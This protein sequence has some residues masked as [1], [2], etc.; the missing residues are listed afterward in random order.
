MAEPRPAAPS[1]RFDFR[2]GIS[3]RGGVERTCAAIENGR[4]RF[5]H[6][7]LDDLSITAVAGC[8]L[9]PM[10]A[11]FLDLCAAIYIADRLSPRQPEGDVRDPFNRWHRPMHLIVPVR[12][13]DWWSQ[14]AIVA[15]LQELLGFLTDDRWSFEFVARTHLLRPSESQTSLFRPPSGGITVALHSGGLDSLLGLVALAKRTSVS[16]IV[17]VTVATGNSWVR[18]VADSVTKELRRAHSSASP[19]YLPVR[20]RIGIHTNGR[21]RNDREPSQR[22]RAMLFLVTG[23]VTALTAGSNRLS[24]CENGVGAISLPMSADHWGAHATKAMH[25]KT[26]TLMSKLA[27]I[28]FDEAMFIDNIGGLSTK[29]ELL[30]LLEDC[31]LTAAQ[32]TASCDQATYLRRGEACGRC[33][34]CL[35]RRVALTTGLLDQVIDGRAMKYQTDWFDRE[36]SWTRANS[37]HLMAMRHQVELLRNAIGDGKDFA[38]LDAAFPDLFEVT[39]LAP[40]LGLSVDD[41]KHRL[42]QLYVSHIREFD[43]FIARIDRQGW[44]RRATVT[45]FS[46]VREDA[47]AG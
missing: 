28:V 3:T 6:Y 29:G 30:L 47:A 41:V 15:R 39:A 22:A 31:H 46:I 37:L 7:W 4:P 16:T 14:P 20:L 38:T 12:H 36:I 34:S 23:L 25:P 32:L 42:L 13:P 40:D 17:P 10:A 27:S 21:R 26:L 33:T 45:E 2:S 11:D 9:P 5:F 24:V 8:P 35:L 43:D 44:G 1:Y 18:H 19:M